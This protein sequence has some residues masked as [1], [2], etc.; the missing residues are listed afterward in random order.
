MDN[1]RLDKIALITKLWPWLFL[2]ALLAFFEVYAQ[3]SAHRSFL[4]NAYNL[5]SIGL[6]AAAPLLLAIGQTFVIIT[7]GID[8]SAGFVM[9]LAAVCV[10]Q[11]TLFGSGS[12]WILIVSIP[13]TIVVCLIPGLVNG[14]LIAWLGVPSPLRAHA[15][16]S[17]AK[18][19]PLSALAPLP[20]RLSL[21]KPKTSRPSCVRPPLRRAAS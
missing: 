10:A 11:F 12:P 19:S 21:P 20:L 7:A 2:A 4:F 15:P 6:A 14:V 8:L 18:T 16:P 3:I 9:G 13:L 5:Q 1:S 17:A